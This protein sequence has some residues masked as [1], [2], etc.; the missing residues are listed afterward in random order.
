MKRINACAVLL[1]ASALAAAAAVP[2]YGQAKYTIEM[3][4]GEVKIV[5]GGAAS[6]AAVDRA[7][8]G[9]DVIVTGKNS[10]ADVSFGDRG[11]VRVQENTRVAMASLKK[12]AEEPD[13]DLGGGGILVMFSKLVKGEVFRVKA[14]TQVAAIRGTSF[15]VTSD[16]GGSRVVVLTGTIAVSP[17][18]DG[19]VRSEI[20]EF[21][22]ENQ[23]V[24]LDRGAVREIIA[25]RRKIVASALSEGDLDKL[26]GRFNNIRESR[27]FKRLRSG[28]RGEIESRIS[29]IRKRRAERG[30]VGP[31]NKREARQIIRQRRG[32]AGR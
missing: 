32:A 12:G 16:G 31:A 3:V 7:L 22:S 15:E 5:S 6:A 30:N 21:V 8:A 1:I 28:L 25:R 29:K 17:V 27:G 13:L 19:T 18:A 24:F 2:G 10:M 26:V 20:Q 14:S 4:V 23:S 11:L 9:G